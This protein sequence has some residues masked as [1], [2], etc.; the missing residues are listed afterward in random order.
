MAQLDARF[1]SFVTSLNNLLHCAWREKDLIHSRINRLRNSTLPVAKLPFELLSDIFELVF[2]SSS[3]YNYG[4]RSA[5][6]AF[7][8]CEQQIRHTRYEIMTTCQQWRLV[9]KSMEKL[10]RMVAIGGRDG[11]PLATIHRQLGTLTLVRALVSAVD[12]ASQPELHAAISLAVLKAEY[13][14]CLAV[15]RPDAPLWSPP[16]GSRTELPYLKKLSYFHESKQSTI[17]VLDLSLA[18]ALRFL[19]VTSISPALIYPPTSSRL[20][21]LS[22]S[23]QILPNNVVSILRSTPN[24]ETLVL[25]LGNTVILDSIIRLPSLIHLSLFNSGRY[26]PPTRVPLRLLDCPKLESLQFYF[27]G[28]NTEGTRGYQSLKYLTVFDNRMENPD[29]DMDNDKAL[30][31]LET[32]ITAHSNIEKLALLSGFEQSALWL[33]DVLQSKDVLPNLRQIE[34]WDKADDLEVLLIARPNID[35]IAP[36]YRVERSD[37]LRECSRV[38]PVHE[39]LIPMSK[40]MWADWAEVASGWR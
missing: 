3:E 34:S 33:S 14:R 24:L 9:L 2:T 10:W 11:R 19:R 22:L 13:L 28:T 25:T 39:D 4:T 37:K 15:E 26:G 1:D 32:T 7:W 36:H 35:I 8:D 38:K 30:E 6:S 40:T 12:E 5:S 27:D 23:G 20:R 29:E 16:S 17:S 31:L 18:S 21:N